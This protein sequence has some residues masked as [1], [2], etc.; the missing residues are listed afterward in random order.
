[1]C[2]C[3]KLIKAIDSYIKKADDDLAEVLEGEGFAEPEATV[4]HISDIE[5]AI[6]DALT[7]E[8][9][10]FI[11][12]A[13]G[14][15]DL[16]EFAKS[17]WPGVKLDDV[18]REKLAEIFQEQLTEF[19]PELVESYIK[20]T[21]RDLTLTKLS[22]R[23]T[24]WIKTWSEDL[25]D[26]M[27]LTSHNE[28]EKILSDNLS[29]GTGIQ[30]F[31]Q[32]I[33]N[34]GIRD[35]YYRARRVAV[36][37]SLRAHSVA[38]EEGLQQS[39]AVESKEWVHT[40]AYRN[41]PRE[42]HIAMSGQIVPKNSPFTLTGADG[43]TYY[44][45][46]PRDINLPAGESVNCHCIHRG[47]VSKDILGLSIEE[48]KRLQAEAVSAMDEQWEKDLDAANKAKAGIE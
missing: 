44:P 8:T 10:Y 39:P 26:L 36:T 17:V 15:V 41:D 6:A 32:D 29:K 20:Q 48:R 11:E 31:I 42:N 40:G 24:A 1:M 22:K 21:D 13:N 27:Q 33:Q 45:Q 47:I 23:T 25:G 9:A 16:D 12:A 28:I 19:M 46:Y 14:A 2:N 4:V 38:A 30:Q 37:E 34:S 35:E 5:A 3:G 43:S 18:A 7:D